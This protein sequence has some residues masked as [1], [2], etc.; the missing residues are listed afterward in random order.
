VDECR[1]QDRHHLANALASLALGEAAGLPMDVMLAAIKSF[2]GLPHRTQW[3]AEKN[4][5]QWINDS[6]GTNVGATLAA[7]DGVKTKN[8]LI[9]IAGGLAKDADFSPL[10]K[11]LKNKSQK[12]EIRAIV[13]MGA[14]AQ[15]IANILDDNI[16]PLY[17]RN[18]SD[19]VQLAAD[20]AED[21][22]TVLLSPACASFDMFSGFKD[23]GN[24]FIQAVTAL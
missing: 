23:R 4:N 14:D 13:L 8:K 3:V 5:V 10:K 24:Q 16:A 11:I 9:L 7:I 20:I 2:G 1:L 15:K 22:D 19:A 17:A 21:G 12:N 18:M 6:K